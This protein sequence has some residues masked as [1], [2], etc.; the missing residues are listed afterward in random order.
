MRFVRMALI[1]GHARNTD[2]RYQVVLHGQG[3]RATAA[4]VLS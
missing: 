4:V 2:K 3:G 1:H